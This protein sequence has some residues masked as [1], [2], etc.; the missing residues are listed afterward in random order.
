MESAPP[1]DKLKALRGFELNRLSGFNGLA[2]T[3][4]AVHGGS[5]SPVAL[6][7]VAKAA[8]EGPEQAWDSFRGKFDELARGQASRVCQPME[9]GED[10]GHYFAA[11]RWM[12]GSHLGIR[13]RDK[14][15]PD[16][17]VALEWTGQLAEA[18]AFLHARGILHRLL[19]PA[20]VFLNDLEQASLLHAGW[21]EVL[22]CAPE[23]L[24]NPAFTSILP[25]A[26]PETAAGEEGDESSDTFSL[27]A[28]LYYLLCGNP[29]FWH[30]DP[31]ELAKR[32]AAEVPDLGPLK[33]KGVRRPVLELVEELMQKK[34][35][36]RPV[37]LPALADRLAALANEPAE[38]AGP[39]TPTASTPPAA[40]AS[41]IQSALETA[42]KAV[43]DPAEE[44]AQGPGG[45]SPGEAA[46][47]PEEGRKRRLAAAVIEEEVVNLREKRKRQVLIGAGAAV[48]LVAAV[49]LGYGVFQVVTAPA[50]PPVERP[51]GGEGPSAEELHR[52]YTEAARQLRQLAQ[53]VRGYERQ[54]GRW[55]TEL[56]E[57][58]ELGA[59]EELFID[60][61]G[62]PVDLRAN[63]VMS[64]GADQTF[65]NE[66]DIWFD[67][68][69][70]R[71]GGYRP[72]LPGRD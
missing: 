2:A 30:D 39:E 55:A 64:A 53:Y 70:M 25:F 13:V 71:P 65:D 7:A 29:P 18:L 15:L 46:V 19:N 60:P 49:G 44:G 23:G 16:M 50:P 63:Y 21:G 51:A 37:N 1:T 48:A 67:A 58:E 41:P 9:C 54:Y 33:E 47:E 42:K 20:S 38:S 66:D 6:V 31:G 26:S 56:E 45:D 35:E 61:W 14:D 12:R 69:E 24:R 22:A 43:K 40:A 27:G 3:Y 52:D 5:S 28:V 57:L 32:I 4:Q 10:Q 36:D 11:Y 68:E 17:A 59:E 62:T 34:P 72:P 8:L